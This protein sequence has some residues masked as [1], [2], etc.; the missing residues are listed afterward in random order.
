MALRASTDTSVSRPPIHT[1]WGMIGAPIV[2][3]GALVVVL[4]SQLMLWLVVVV[5]KK[6]GW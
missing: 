4:P 1:R 5:K 2:G 3:I 6:C